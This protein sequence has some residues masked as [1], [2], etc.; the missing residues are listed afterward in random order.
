MKIASIFLNV[1]ML[2]QMAVIVA[3]HNHYH[4][5][6]VMKCGT[7]SPNTTMVALDI[8]RGNLFKKK[9][10]RR[11]QAQSC[12]DL[13]EKCIEIQVYIHF[14]QF[15]GQ[16]V[17]LDFDFIPHPTLNVVNLWLYNDTSL[18]VDDFTSVEDMLDLVDKQIDVMNEKYA[19]TPFF[20]TH[21]ER[22]NPS[23]TVNT[24]WAINAPVSNM[25]QALGKG[26]LSTLN[27]YFG[28]TVSEEAD[29]MAFSH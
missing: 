3:S 20:F 6:E 5:D 2:L 12:E 1:F 11:A 17:G 16:D 10:G 9:H 18:T 24:E 8:A 14:M 29:V 28:F 13:C 25:S 4:G 21:M 7:K 22:D 26:N 23:V 19:D 15:A 27:L